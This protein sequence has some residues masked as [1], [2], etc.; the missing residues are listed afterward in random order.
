LQGEASPGY[1]LLSLEHGHHNAAVSICRLPMQ[2]RIIFGYI[3]G[4]VILFFV[5]WREGRGLIVAGK[6]WLGVVGI[7]FCYYLY[8][9]WLYF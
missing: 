8:I 1:G 7:G 6:R 9:N 4:A 5:V 2:Q 3:A